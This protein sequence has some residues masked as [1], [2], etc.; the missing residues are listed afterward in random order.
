M[1]TDILIRCPSSPLAKAFPRNVQ[2]DRYRDIFLLATQPPGDG[3]IQTNINGS[4]TAQRIY[5]MPYCEGEPGS[6][7]FMRLYG[8]RSITAKTGGSDN[9]VWVY[10][11]LAEFVC[12]SGA[13]A[14]PVLNQTAAPGPA[15]FGLPIGPTENMCQSISM[16]SG[17][18][19][20]TG[21]INSM[22]PGSIMPACAGVELCGAQL[23]SFDFEQAP[24][25][26]LGSTLAANCLWSM[27]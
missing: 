6:I 15:G 10:F 21:F 16:L 13:I 27:L 7:F 23:V 18:L 26:G 19:G 5:L 12:V 24:S 20:L 17:V 11:L 8:W 25:G 4:F 3:V 14:G 1:A 9:T 22:P 2:Q